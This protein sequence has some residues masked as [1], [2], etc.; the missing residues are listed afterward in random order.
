MYV[1]RHVK[2]P[3]FLLCF[4]EIWTFLTYF[5]KGPQISNFVNISLV[6]TGFFHVEGRTDMTKLVVIFRSLRMLLKT[7]C[8]FRIDFVKNQTWI[9]HI[10]CLEVQVKHFNFVMYFEAGG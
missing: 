8:H 10:T 6:G 5:R 9:L 1:R 7:T 4:N 2:Y 3:L